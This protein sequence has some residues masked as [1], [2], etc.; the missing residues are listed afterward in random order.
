[1]N[2]YRASA[3]TSAASPAR[4]ASPCVDG[5]SS[6][7][8]VCLALL[9]ALRVALTAPYLAAVHALPDNS[10][11]WRSRSALPS[12]VFARVNFV[13]AAPAS[14]SSRRHS[15]VKPPPALHHLLQ[16]LV[17]HRGHKVVL[18]DSRVVAF[19]FFCGLFLCLLLLIRFFHLC[20]SCC[21][22]S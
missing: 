1:M 13:V 19:V 10:V 2:R 4:C 16:F 15:P 7:T 22:C 8:G 21:P 3:S 6:P 17:G 20:S 9:L 11:I 14:A 18:L 12:G 5:P